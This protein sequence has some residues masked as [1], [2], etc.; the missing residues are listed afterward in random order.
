MRAKIYT[1]SRGLKAYLT[2]DSPASN[3]GVPVL[4]VEG[5]G[6]EDW[7]DMGPADILESGVSAA[8][9]VCACAAGTLPPWVGGT[10]HTMNAKT[11]E[12]ARRFCE[13][14]PKGPQI[15]KD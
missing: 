14:W 10:I 12:A 3:H 15:G 4:R 2:T 8:A 13:Q 11:R 1:G 5:P 6:V 7:P 9:L